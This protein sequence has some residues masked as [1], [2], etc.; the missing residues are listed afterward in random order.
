[1][2]VWEE[3]ARSNFLIRLRSW[4]YWPFGIVQFPAIIYWLWLSLRT[5]S[6]TFF[7]ASNPGIVM[8]GMFGESKYEILFKIP[9][10]YVPKT[11]LVQLPVNK[12]QLLQKIKSAGMQFP[13]IFK[14][15]IGERG[16]MVKKISR[17]KEIDDYLAQI[18]LNF[19]AQEWVDL[20][21]EFS[22]FFIRFPEE[23]EGRVTSVVAKK[24]LA[25]EGDGKSTFKE[26]VLSNDRA[27]LQWKK[28]QVTYRD[29]LESVIP[30]GEKIELVPI[31]NH[32]LG[33]TFLD[34]NFL[35]N[36]KLSHTFNSISRGIEGFY[37]GR[38]DL[39][40]ASLEELYAGNIRIL[41]LNGCGAEP[42]H[43]YDPQFPF[44]KAVRVLLRHWKNIFRIAR[45]NKERGADYMRFKDALK[46]Y[47]RFKA[48]T[49]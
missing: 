39:R 32:A 36:D 25:I 27:K 13:V 2:N 17:E 22:V 7:T 42:I 31:G 29:Q 4:E 48:A 30:H 49:K 3:I 16:F 20:P 15:D 24:M 28:L 9:G 33:T 5:R 45:T 11:I 21:L 14:P 44:L 40:C 47:R 46:Y 1:M 34:A 37:F 6:L 18:R 23:P 35:I 8:G 19:L 41:E 43:I 26:L 38:F 10:D 12:Q